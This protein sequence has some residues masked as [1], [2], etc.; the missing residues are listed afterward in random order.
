MRGLVVRSSDHRG[1][2]Y[3]LAALIGRVNW[4]KTTASGSASV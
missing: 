3:R 2:P 1:P 4:D